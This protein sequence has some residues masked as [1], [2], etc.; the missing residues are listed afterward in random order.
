MEQ[1]TIT[2]STLSSEDRIIVEQ[3]LEALPPQGKF[4]IS[5]LYLFE[6]TESEVANQLNMTQQA[7]NKWKKKML[8]KLSQ[9]MNS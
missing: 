8:R 1:F 4:I 5:Q 9:T 3:L 7:V 6:Q 2:S